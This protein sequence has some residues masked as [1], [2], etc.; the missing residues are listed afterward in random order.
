VIKLLTGPSGFRIPVVRRDFF[1][2]QE[3][4]PSLV[5]T[6]SSIQWVPGFCPRRKAT[7]ASS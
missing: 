5:P 1:L 3:S 2:L 7:G 4:R 6:R